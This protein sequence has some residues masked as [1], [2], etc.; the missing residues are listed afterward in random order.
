MFST[1][2]ISTSGLYAQRVRMDVI[3]NNLANVNTT[4]DAE[5]RPNPY[6]RQDVVFRVGAPQFG[7]RAE[8]VHVPLVT[9]DSRP[10]RK[11]FD[12]QHPDAIQEG[13]DAGYVRLP[14]VEPMVEMVNM[15]DATRAYEANA[16]VVSV[17]KGLFSSALRILA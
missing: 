13:P 17:T 1:L 7:L 11:E 9:D 12:P 2:D 10:F 8:G 16:T 14:N 4:R 6:R 15:I 5:G 3:A